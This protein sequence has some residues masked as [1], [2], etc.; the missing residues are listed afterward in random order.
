MKWNYRV[1]NGLVYVE[2]M[3]P[4]GP[5]GHL[6]RYLLDSGAIGSARPRA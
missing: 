1:T 6:F 3:A 2:D 5:P 4:E